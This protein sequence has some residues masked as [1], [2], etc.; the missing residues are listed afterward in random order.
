MVNYCYISMCSFYVLI[1]ARFIV[2]NLKERKTSEEL[3]IN[4]PKAREHVLTALGISTG[5]PIPVLDHW[6][7][8]QC[9]HYQNKLNLSQG[10]LEIR[11]VLYYAFRKEFS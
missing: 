3:E 5:A 10:L 2:V 6:E 1:C 7:T 11:K 8:F 9:K 4:D